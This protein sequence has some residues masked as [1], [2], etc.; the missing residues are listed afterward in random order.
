MNDRTP[1]NPPAAEAA[2]ATAA[3][4]VP[5][6]PPPAR[7]GRGGNR[8][9]G[10][11]PKYKKDKLGQPAYVSLTMDEKRQVKRQAKTLGL[12]ISCYIRKKLGLST[13]V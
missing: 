1:S 10:R 13:D 2:T 11:P 12:S 6:A 3:E 5:E 4:A 8:G 7:S 9:G